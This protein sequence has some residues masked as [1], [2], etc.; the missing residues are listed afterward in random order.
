MARCSKT[1]P[2]EKFRF[3]VTFSDN[4]T[5]S[6]GSKIKAGFHDIQM[7]KRSTTKIAYREGVDP[8]ISS[9]SAG[10][11][12]MEDIV[13]NRGLL[14]VEANNGSL[15]DIDGLYKW[16]SAIHNPVN[17]TTYFNRVVDPVVQNPDSVDD[18]RKDVTIEMYGRAGTVA[19]VWKLYNAFP[20]NFVPASDLNASEDGEKAMESVTLAY[21][22]FQELESDGKTP[23]PVTGS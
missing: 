5:G 3:R 11:S 12:S 10:L 18:Y 8:D 16:M 22:D 23:A 17:T 4:E 20:V 15:D 9:Q 6:E 13:L 21:E 2:L 14:S 1:D 7:P 19:R